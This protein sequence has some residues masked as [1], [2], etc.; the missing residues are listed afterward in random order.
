[1]LLNQEIVPTQIFLQNH[2]RQ[3]WQEEKKAPFQ[4]DSELFHKYAGR[5]KLN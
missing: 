4:F 3:A 5:E 1:M 2:P